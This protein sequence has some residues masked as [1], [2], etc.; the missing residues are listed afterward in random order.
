MAASKYFQVPIGGP[1][2]RRAA[3]IT[4]RTSNCQLAPSRFH[5][6]NRPAVVIRPW[7]FE[8]S[9]LGLAIA[10]I[11]ALAGS[12][13]GQSFVAQS[14]ALT[15]TTTANPDISE[16]G[17][18]SLTR[19]RWVVSGG[20][21]AEFPVEFSG[22]IPVEWFFRRLRSRSYARRFSAATSTFGACS[23]WESSITRHSS[24]MSEA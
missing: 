7:L 22:G 2:L 1:V 15:S 24:A 9:S 14:L 20:I 5:A 4:G 3:W 16:L 12:P 10:S 17:V 23:A 6:A 11:R 8:G 21:S 19:A 18:I 13:S